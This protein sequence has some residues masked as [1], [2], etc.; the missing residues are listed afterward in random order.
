MRAVCV[1]AR[2]RVGGVTRLYDD[3]CA[4]LSSSALRFFGERES[5]ATKQ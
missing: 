2:A 4:L 3:T 5:V 1:R